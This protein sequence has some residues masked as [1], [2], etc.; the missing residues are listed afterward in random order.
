MIQEAIR[1]TG[2]YPDVYLKD[3]K[4]LVM[5]LRTAKRDLAA[6]KVVY[7][8]RTNPEKKISVK[9][10]CTLRDGLFDYYQAELEFSS[11]ARYQKYYFEMEESG[12]IWYL[13]AWGIHEQVPE[14]G[15]FEFL[16]ANSTEILDVPKWS[17]G[18]VYYQIFPERFYN[19]DKTNDP[20]DSVEWG[21]RPT[22]ENYM[23]GDLQG[24]IE[25]LD[26]IKDLGIDC[27]YLNPIFEA[28]FN[29]KYA[30][31]N[32]Y[33][34][35]PMFGNHE[36]FRHLITRAHGMG[37]KIIL[38]G[39]FNHSGIHF[40][41]FQ[42]VLK[43]QKNSK[44]LEW[45]HFT[46]FPVSV[47]HHCYECVG[48]YKYMPK[49]NT[50]NP[51][52]QR[53][54]L[55]VMDYWIREFQIDGWRLDVADEVDESVWM[56][57]RVK[58]KQK[59]PDLLLLGETWGQGLRLLDGSQMDCIMNYTFRDAV[60]DFIAFEKIDADGFNDRLQSMLAKYPEAVNQAMFLPLDS[61]DT[62]RFQFYCNGDRKKQIL[63]IIFQMT[64][65]GSPSV[66]YGDEIGITGNND[67]DCRKCMIW[68]EERQD[69]ELLALYQ[70]LIQLRKQEECIKTGGFTVNLCEDRV[71]GFIRDKGEEQIYVVIN[72]GS[73][74]K[75]AKIPVLHKA[76]YADLID[77]EEYA[78][79]DGIYE[80]C[81]NSD[82]LD[83]RGVIK[84]ELEP[85]SA[86]IIKRRI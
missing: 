44:Y 47:S 57:A 23:G 8:A 37:I 74:S 59:Y 29:H 62:E 3:R 39:V 83:Y 40:E 73:K 45:F 13:S 71:Y 14:D 11:V 78:V 10:K 27:I 86:K 34:I 6:C 24:I 46:G 65:V 4:R 72:A 30:T 84:V 26:Y 42:D 54:I 51:E 61:H 77:G 52:V 32:Y 36:T 82:M 15:Y 1:H 35:D 12:V 50:S 25:K 56:E 19:G 80:T 43:N 70:N 9:M 5:M 63:A 16:Y 33:K 49:L 18:Q 76:E 41:P 48:A 85:F 28:D 22:R 55:D 69:K 64:F 53:F 67:P 68:E 75:T 66:Y 60:R 81:L 20:S 21:S 79:R 31:T 7:F 38:D 58:L 17:R 2:T